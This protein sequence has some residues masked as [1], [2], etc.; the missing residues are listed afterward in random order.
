[1]AKKN[2]DLVQFAV[3]A[4]KYNTLL[5]TKYKNRKVWVNPNPYDVQSFIPGTILEISV[6]EGEV[7]SEGSPLLILEAMKMQN[8]IQMPFTARIK[9]IN[10]TL[11]ARI[12]KDTLMI[13][14][15]AVEEE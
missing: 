3:T 9:K 11:G 13:E 1:M 14:L 2:P 12:P 8:R 4:R 10:V 6:K 7:V 15:E 5:T